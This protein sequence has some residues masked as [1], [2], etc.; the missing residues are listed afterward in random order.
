MI[1][2]IAVLGRPFLASTACTCAFEISS[3]HPSPGETVTITGSANPGQEIKFQTSSQMSLPVNSG[4]Y[5]YETSSVEIP[6]KPNRFAVKVGGVKD[7]NV[8]VKIGI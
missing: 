7:L 8:G 5:E 6:Q 4:R 2:P 3:N 1:K